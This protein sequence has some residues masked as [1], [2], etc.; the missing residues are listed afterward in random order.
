MSRA[1]ARGRQIAIV[2]AADS[3]GRAHGAMSGPKAA[4]PRQLC[5]DLTRFP[6]KMAA[7]FA[8]QIRRPGHRIFHK[9]LSGHHGH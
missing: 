7:I 9:P 1:A 2:Q 6:E 4:H 8:T 5:L 3:I